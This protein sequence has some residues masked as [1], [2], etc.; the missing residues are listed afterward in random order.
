MHAPSPTG[1]NPKP[2][3][4]S[5]V[6]WELQLQSQSLLDI[7]AALVSVLVLARVTIRM[8]SVVANSERRIV[9]GMR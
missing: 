1:F 5:L 9:L 3:A 4:Q 7:V 2:L 6:H 8:A